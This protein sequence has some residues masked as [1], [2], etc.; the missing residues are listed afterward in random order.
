MPSRQPFLKPVQRIPGPRAVAWQRRRRHI[1][2]THPGNH[3]G[4]RSTVKAR[5]YSIVYL[6]F[7]S[8]LPIYLTI[9]LLIYFSTCDN[10]PADQSTDQSTTYWLTI[11]Q[12]TNSNGRTYSSIV[13]WYACMLV[14]YIILWFWSSRCLLGVK[15]RSRLWHWHPCSLVAEFGGVLSAAEGSV[16]HRE[17][18][19]AEKGL[20]FHSDTIDICGRTTTINPSDTTN[21]HKIH[22]HKPIQYAYKSRWRTAVPFC[23]IGPHVP[24][25]RLS[26]M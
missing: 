21:L 1:R 20:G 4:K 25:C 23:R 26:A 2:I 24:R 15:T 9:H 19:G 10:Q 11:V 7:E 18:S 6:Q 14:L 13:D 17:R 22:E 16:Y 12:Q 3:L 8:S 5:V